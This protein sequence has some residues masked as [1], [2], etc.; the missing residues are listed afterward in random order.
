MDIKLRVAVCLY[1]VT[2]LPDV[3]KI[4]PWVQGL[5]G[6]KNKRNGID[7]KEINTSFLLFYFSASVPSMNSSN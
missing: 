3:T 5:K 7:I 1:G 6:K 2:M 4:L